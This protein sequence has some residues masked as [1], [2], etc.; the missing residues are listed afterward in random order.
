[1]VGVRKSI[2]VAYCGAFGA[3]VHKLYSLV[4][5]PRDYTRPGS[6]HNVLHFSIV[7]LDTVADVY[8]HVHVHACT[9]GLVSGQARSVP[10]FSAAQS[11]AC[12][13]IL[14]E[15]EEAISILKINFN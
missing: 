10:F 8:I 3:A 1:M 11:L 12:N 13:N 2:H 15:K 5:T 6:L 4:T 14:I 9:C 7:R